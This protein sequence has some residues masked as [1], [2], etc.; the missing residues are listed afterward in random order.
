MHALIFCINLPLKQVKEYKHLGIM[1]SYKYLSKET[2]KV[3]AKQA[4]KALF[5][6]MKQLL[7]L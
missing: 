5:S 4:N 7:N 2:T 1:L 6:L 3:L